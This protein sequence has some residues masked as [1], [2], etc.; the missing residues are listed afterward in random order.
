MDYKILDFNIIGDQ[1]GLLISFEENNNIPFDIK[2]VF[3]IFDT[4]GDVIRGAHSNKNSNFLL[5]AINGSC[6]VKIDNGSEQVEFL[7]NRP[8]KGL[9]IKNNVWKE[10]YEFSYNAILMVLSNQYYN[11]NEYIRNYD[12]FLKEIGKEAGKVNV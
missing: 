9:F 10:M 12:E 3:Y 8:D 4:K 6:K 7:L 11:E 5:I 1:R 2:R